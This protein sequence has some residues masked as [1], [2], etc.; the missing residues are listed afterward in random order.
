V[1]AHVNGQKSDSADSGLRNTENAILGENLP[2]VAASL[3]YDVLR[4][5]RDME[6]HQKRYRI[7]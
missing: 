3:F 6:R 5:E 1:F 2:P 4:I 7:Q